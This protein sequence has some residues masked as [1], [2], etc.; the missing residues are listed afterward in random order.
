[1][2]FYVILN[3]KILVKRKSLQE[4]SSLNIKLGRRIR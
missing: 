4:T 2:Q 3:I 1:M